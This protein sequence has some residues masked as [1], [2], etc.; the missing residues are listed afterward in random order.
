M[1]STRVLPCWEFRFPGMGWLK[2]IGNLRPLGLLLTTFIAA[3]RGGASEAEEEHGIL[4]FVANGDTTVVEQYR[5]TENLLTGELRMRYENGVAPVRYRISLGG[6]GRP[7]RVELSIWRVDGQPEGPPVREWIVVF[8][9]DTVIEEVRSGRA[10]RIDTTSTREGAVP[11]FAPSM[12]MLQEA[13]RQARHLSSG[14]E[15]VELPVYA[16]AEQRQT[17]TVV[18]NWSGLNSAVI[19]FDG[20]AEGLLLN[21]DAQGRILGGASPDS[22]YE[23]VRR[24]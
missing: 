20:T 22:T 24:R 7:T 15:P 17:R 5:R 11:L 19:E 14:T 4:A 6:S 10:I 23:I 9:G 16:L 3:C 8:R 18:I 1:R 13:T 21:I 12:V 2:R